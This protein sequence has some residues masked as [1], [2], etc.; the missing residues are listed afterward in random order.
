MITRSFFLIAL[1]VIISLHGISQIPTSGLDL[2]LRA[3]A[4]VQTSGTAVTSWQDLSGNN[5]HATQGNV[6]WQPQLAQNALN[7]LPVIHFTSAGQR[8]STPAF[9]VFPSNEG[10]LYAVVRSTSS[11][12]GTIMGTYYQASQNFQWGISG[13]GSLRNYSWFQGP[14]GGSGTTY[15]T[16]QPDQ[17]EVIAVKKSGSTYTFYR[18]GQQVNQLTSGAYSSLLDAVSVFLGTNHVGAE[19]FTGYMA[20]I[21]AYGGAQSDADRA[22]ITNYLA[23]KYALP[24]LATTN[25]VYRA[26]ATGS[27]INVPYNAA[28]PFQG[29]NN[30]TIS[31]YVNFESFAAAGGPILMTHYGG[32]EFWYRP[33]LNQMRINTSFTTT[34]MDAPWTAQ[35]NTWYHL[36]LTRNGNDCRFYV[37]GNLQHQ[38]TYS[39]P[40]AATGSG[41]IIG[42]YPAG[43]Y[44]FLGRMDEVSLWN[45]GV[46]PAQVQDLM[47][48]PLLGNEA[49]LV[50]YYTMQVAGEGNG[51]QVPNMCVNTGAALNGTTSGGV[52]SPQ[53]IADAAVAGSASSCSYLIQSSGAGLAFD[54]VNDYAEAA[55]DVQLDFGTGDFTVEYWVKKRTASVNN[56]DNMAGVNKWL[57]G[58]SSPGQNEWSLAMGSNANNNIPAFF[59]ESGATTYGAISAQSMAVG[60]WQHLAGVR[61]GNTLRIYL[62]GVQTGS[63]TLPAN[64]S[65]NNVGRTL[66][67]AVTGSND[68]HSDVVLDEV[69]IWNTAR[70]AQ[71]IQQKLNT[72]LDSI[73]CTLLVYYKFNQG[74]ADVYNEGLTTIND[75]AGS[76]N[77]AILYNSLLN[78]SASNWTQGSGI[79]EVSS[80]PEVVT[81]FLD[82]DN[83]GF[84]T[85]S[86]VSSC[87]S[88]GAGYSSNTGLYA[89]DCDDSN[90]LIN[91]A[92]PELCGNGIDDDCNPSSPDDCGTVFLTA[93]SNVICNGLPV[94]LTAGPFNP[95]GSFV[96]SRDGVVIPGSGTSIN[97]NQ[98]GVY[99]VVVPVGAMVIVSGQSTFT[100]PAYYA[101]PEPVTLVAE[102]TDV[103][104]ISPSPQG[105]LCAGT[106]VTLTASSAASYE[107]STDETSQSIVVTSAGSYSVT[108][109]GPNG[110][111]A[112]SQPFNVVY[113]G[114]L[115]DFTASSTVQYI[116][117]TP[118]ISFSA[119][120]SG[121]IISYS[122]NF[123]D[124]SPVSSAASPVH[125]YIN[126]GFYDVTL[127][128]E[129]DNGCTGSMTKTNYIEVWEVFDTEPA[130]LGVSNDVS[131]VSFISP[132]AGCVAIRNN[133]SS[134]VCLTTNG[135][136][137]GAWIPLNAP[138]GGSQPTRIRLTGNAGWLTGT[139]G[140]LCVSFDGG[141]TWTPI[142]LGV[143]NDINTITFSDN[144][145]GYLAGSGGLLCVYNNGTW[146]PVTGLPSGPGFDDISQYTF[147]DIVSGG[148]NG[149]WFG[150][151]ANGPGGGRY[152][153]CIIQGGNP[154]WYYYPYGPGFQA[155]GISFLG[156]YVGGFGS[157]G[158]FGGGSGGGYSA[159]VAGSNSSVYGTSDGGLT[160]TLLTSGLTPYTLRDIEIIDANHA[161]CVGDNG[162]VL[163]TDDGGATWDV[164]N[165][166]DGQDLT[167]VTFKDCNAYI[168]GSTGRV[169][170][171]PI[172][173]TPELPQIAITGATSICSGETTTVEV[174]NARPGNTYLWSN[175]QTGTSALVN[176]AGNYF[177]TEFSA[178][179]TIVSNTV[180]VDAELQLTY[181]LDADGDGFGNPSVTQL[182][183]NPSNGYILQAGDCDDSNSQRYPGAP[184]ICGNG[185]DDDCDG[186]TDEGCGQPTAPPNDLRNNA[187]VISSNPFGVCT[188]TNGTVNGATVS[189]QSTSPVV[190]GEDVWYRFTANSPGVSIR[191]QTTTF[192]A[193][194][195]LQDA[196][197]NVIDVEN[198]VAGSGP[199]ILNL[200]NSLSPLVNGQQYIIAVRNMDSAQGTG[201]FTICVQR[202]RPTSCNV[203][204]NSFQTCDFF[205]ATFVG[206]QSYIFDFTD[207]ETSEL[208]SATSYN[209]YTRTQLGFVLP[210]HSYSVT[211]TAVFN[212]FD[213]AG[214]PEVIQIVTPN[215]C[216]I[217]IEPHISLTMRTQDQCP[218]G[219]RPVNGMI[220]AH[221]WICGAT[222]YE[223][224]FRQTLPSPAPLFSEPVAGLPV[225]RFLNLAPL[226]LIPGAT[227]EV[228]IRPVFPN[229][230]SG[231]WSL[232]PS[233]LQII[234]PASGF[235]GNDQSALDW[236]SSE[237]AQLALYPNP[238]RDGMVNLSLI[239]MDAGHYTMVVV[240]QTGRM[241]HQEK[242]VAET[243]GALNRQLMLDLASGIYTVRVHGADTDLHVKWVIQP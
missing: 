227:Y 165:I 177:V 114:P 107:W 105:V 164:W 156:G 25:I 174:T 141:T 240:D 49:G 46:T 196:A 238:S 68:F 195:E 15:L 103:P 186:A 67:M 159:C 217:T 237:E 201:T 131:S 3:D 83:D 143:S 211:L 12:Y 27:Q 93:S 34:M 14:F 39:A 75:L 144:F 26:T 117:T 133:A 65:V 125:S 152:F 16:S 180:T 92:A 115:S 182:T 200:Y 134:G 161:V 146:S 43:G 19:A 121:T 124:G 29:T 148:A 136:Q 8:L 82:A 17:F 170:R 173:F 94:T 137:G 221:T 101:S 53:F 126:D 73:P 70:T 172:N 128:V 50:A 155:W 184:E 123:G 239:R 69:R 120:T 55:D 132:N 11:S 158:T 199:E 99:S 205:K 241:V 209:G 130:G 32:L 104:V 85:G 194:I 90:A 153:G 235:A 54:G 91:P 139:N 162:T 10:T 24:T 1:A 176:I 96:W 106:P 135:G 167:E 175:G 216:I 81:W 77:N 189:P 63:T 80:T 163:T 224:R 226:Q 140:L 160:W 218:Q 145:N 64:A 150:G 40:F 87:I 38:V 5:R 89:G 127:T 149:G 44:Q 28:F 95:Y 168:C 232:A 78:G 102:F 41:L 169:F 79:T 230:Y 222:H 59:I 2:W 20:E 9:S 193:V 88:P 113:A 100:V 84:Y 190:T 197:G 204:E 181:Y 60:S 57:S 42:N 4:G 72:E 142:D 188:A 191:V 215:S 109:S 214:N 110:C 7:G 242:L 192:N 198:A 151:I 74:T 51:V 122:W 118:P 86:P 219:P 119:V 21:I 111:S 129:D 62:N 112:T 166:G 179:D 233:C 229:D 76:D 48:E 37:N 185:V 212:L 183:C 202:L 171:F 236:V 220:A 45:V 18:G 234:G 98:P 61:E 33:T 56:W 154:Y 116:P 178:C 147:S 6:S 13:S 36:V 35:L 213:G 138:V 207:L 228:E 47:N 108:V 52:G 243:S 210:E 208:Y 71:Q 30:F 58:G 203:T 157:G 97:V 23:C 206:A 31:M 22:E 187:I 223:W 231:D 66:R 225:N